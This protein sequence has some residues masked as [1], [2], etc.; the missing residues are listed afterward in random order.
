MC[1][2]LQE[3]N[4]EKEKDLENQRK[5]KK[6]FPSD[7]PRLNSAHSARP[8]PRPRPPCPAD[9]WTPCPF[10]LTGGARLS[11]SFPPPF[12]FCSAGAAVP[13]C[14]VRMGIRP[15]DPLPRS[16]EAPF[17]YFP[18]SLSFFPRSPSLCA[19]AAVS[20]WPR[21][22]IG[23]I[24]VDSFPFHPSP[25]AYKYHPNPRLRFQAPV[26][27]PEPSSALPTMCHRRRAIAA[28]VKHLQSLSAHPEDADMLSEARH[29]LSGL[30]RA[31]SDSQSTQPR[32]LDHTGAPPTA[33]RR[34]QPSSPRLRSR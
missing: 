10:S 15:R 29:C 14:H 6:H 2:S 22:P 32:H 33:V 31:R 24:P 8:R 13:R 1:S 16:S 17:P 23:S 21:D 34:R 7:G 20:P 25:S 26:P 27:A 12:L 28:V 5:R 18:S 3:K 30:R 19:S 4:L 11:V 9:R